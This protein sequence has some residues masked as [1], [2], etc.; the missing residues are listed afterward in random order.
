MGRSADG[1]DPFA[2][3]F[4]AGEFCSRPEVTRVLLSVRPSAAYIMAAPGEV[5]QGGP[6]PREGRHTPQF[7]AAHP[8]QAMSFVCGLMRSLT[9]PEVEITWVGHATVLIEMDGVRLLTDPVLRHRIGP[10]VRLVRDP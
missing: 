10:L 7:R 8:V 9:M 3:A 5:A 4:A 2:A 1:L 6:R